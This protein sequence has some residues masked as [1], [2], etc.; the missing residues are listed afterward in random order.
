M[1]IIAIKFALTPIHF[2]QV[3]NFRRVERKRA[4]RRPSGHIVM[5]CKVGRRRLVLASW[6][7]LA[8]LG[9]AVPLSDTTPKDGRSTVVARDS[10]RRWVPSRVLKGP[11]S[12]TIRLHLTWTLLLHFSN[13]CVLGV[14][15]NCGVSGKLENKRWIAKRTNAH[16]PMHK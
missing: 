9:D 7:A 15:P 11:P 10:R 4:M 5:L 3:G 8:T 2:V 14:T 16:N 12:L 13:V 6:R 1:V